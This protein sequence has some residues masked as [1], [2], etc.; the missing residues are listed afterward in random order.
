[1]TADSKVQTQQG[2]VRVPNPP[3]VAAGRRNSALR[4]P[5]TDEGR[6]RLREAAL[7]NRPWE[8]ST[9]P[10]TPEGK[11]KAAL[12]GKA[13]QIGPLSVR[14]LRAELSRV[15][16]LAMRMREARAGLQP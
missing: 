2:V 5:L 1:M 11:A 10:R 4:G 15:K 8:R 7:R 12:N 14:E 6:E 13:R 3:R 16:D 9:G